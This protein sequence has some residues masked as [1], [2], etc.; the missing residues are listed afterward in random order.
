[1]MMARATGAEA[2]FG[3]RE[4]IEVGV[5]TLGLG[6]AAFALTNAATATMSA[7]DQAKPGAS[8]ADTIITKDVAML[9]TTSFPDLADRGDPSVVVDGGAATI[10]LAADPSKVTPHDYAAIVHRI[11]DYY[12]PSPRAVDGVAVLDSFRI[13]ACPW[14]T[15]CTSGQLP[16]AAELAA[17]QPGWAPY[18]DAGSFERSDYGALVT[19]PVP[20]R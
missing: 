15:T 17:A 19:L 11:A 16:A 14:E 8:R 7:M 2:R 3:W 6:F 5:F 12:E 18:V 20:P 10:T 9:V 4:I 13:T 1:M